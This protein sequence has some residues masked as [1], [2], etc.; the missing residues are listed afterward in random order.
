VVA[1]ALQSDA[2]CVLN[3]QKE[4]LGRGK[5]W[6]LSWSPHPG[7]TSYT[8][9]QIRED[10]ETGTVT[11]RKVTVQPRGGATRITREVGVL[12]TVPLTITYRITAV[13][14]PE[15]CSG[16]IDVSYPTDTKFQQI[17]RKSVIPLVGS[18]RGANG[19][20]FK[21][22]LRLRGTGGTQRG[23][24]VFHPANVP[25][26]DTDPSMTYEIV[27]SSSIVEYDD[28]VTAFGATGIGTIDIIP[29]FSSSNG[30]TV[31]AAEVRLFNV[32]DVGTFGTIEPQTQAYDFLGEHVDPIKSLSVTV[33]DPAI[34]RLNLA[35]RSFDDDVLALVEVR[36][37]G[38]TIVSKNFTLDRDFLLF[39]SAAV[40]TGIAL[41]SGDI[42][43]ISLPEGGGVPMYTLTD[44]RTN[45]PALFMPPV[46]IQTNVG[47]YDVGF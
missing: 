39:N 6:E 37:Q 28:I 14:S 13:G 36:R 29:D 17:T 40:M 15:P 18:A 31:P 2:A 1:V 23:I 35:V 12:T 16:T 21:T 46:R 33:P 4:D 24:L 43:T 20:L 34:L 42:I 3:L 32:T 30:W 7:A 19:S 8:V 38:V 27:G 25:P 10:E 11:I 47:V 41:Q 26:H 45:D 5:R 22:S 44:Q 9:E